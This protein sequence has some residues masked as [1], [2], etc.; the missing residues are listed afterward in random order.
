MVDEIVEPARAMLIPGFDQLKE[1]AK[2]AGALGCGISGSGPSVFAL[3]RGMTKANQVAESMAEV[4]NKIGVPYEVH[5]C[6]INPNGV[7]F[8]DSNNA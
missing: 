8:L 7:Q 4:Y 6:P 1:N 3:S 2:N 5:V